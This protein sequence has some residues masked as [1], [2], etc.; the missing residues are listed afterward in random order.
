MKPAKN[1]SAAKQS[2]GAR[3]KSDLRTATIPAKANLPEQPYSREMEIL[4]VK[5]LEGAH[6]EVMRLL[7]ESKTELASKEERIATLKAEL[8][9]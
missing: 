7:E 9:V 2:G 5:E 1:A 3:L 6:A 8:G 4:Q